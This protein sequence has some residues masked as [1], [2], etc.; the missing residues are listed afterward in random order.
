MTVFAFKNT[1]A[2]KVLKK[3]PVENK[4]FIDSNE[5]AID[6]LIKNIVKLQ[7]SYI[8]GLGEY[9]GRDKGKLRIETIC[10]NKFRNQI[11]GN[12]LR[13]VGISSFLTSSLHSKY[14]TGIG[15]SYCNLVSFKIM[16]A[17]RTNKSKSQYGFIHIPKNFDVTLAVI[18]SNQYILL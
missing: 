14:A 17:L 11:V 4:F 12:G 1:I 16:E 2:D 9:S 8:I 13:Q 7:P 5:A 10:T 3:L 6:K 15:N 18:E